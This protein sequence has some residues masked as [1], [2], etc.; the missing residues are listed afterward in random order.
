MFVLV[1]IA[2]GD[3][4]DI[5]LSS[6]E[7]ESVTVSELVNRLD[8]LEDLRGR[9]KVLIVESCR[10]ENENTGFKVH[11]FFYIYCKHQFLNKDLKPK[12]YIQV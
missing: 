6:D 12:H 7:K 10:G 11:L 2:H 9:P 4:G 5:I 1:V 8:A 3:K